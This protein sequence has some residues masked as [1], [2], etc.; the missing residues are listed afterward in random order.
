MKCSISQLPALL[1]TS[2]LEYQLGP[3]RY[4]HILDMGR[5]CTPQADISPIAM[6]PFPY[7][8]RSLIEE[9]TLFLNIECS[10]AIVKENDT[11]PHNIISRQN[12]YCVKIS[13][14]L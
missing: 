3:C 2:L 7:H 5:S 14:F 6:S 4:N 10:L 8:W 1:Y 12:Q 13:T 11:I 9:H